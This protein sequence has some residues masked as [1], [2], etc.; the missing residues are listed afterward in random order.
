[1]KERWVRHIESAR[2][3]YLICVR[4]SE[5]KPPLWTWEDNIKMTIEE[6][7]ENVVRFHLAQNRNQW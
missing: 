3:S 7:C 1:M 2:S 6:M 4:K 5:G